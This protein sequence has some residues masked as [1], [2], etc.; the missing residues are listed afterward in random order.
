M[1]ARGEIEFSFC[2]TEDMIADLMTKILSGATFDRPALLFYFL[3]TYP[4]L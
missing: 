1:V 3:G 4:P 2:F